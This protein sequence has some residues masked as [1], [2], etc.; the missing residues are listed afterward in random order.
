[1]TMN[2]ITKGMMI[3]LA[4][5]LISDVAGKYIPQVQGV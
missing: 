5:V 4:V 3:G 2:S 1:M